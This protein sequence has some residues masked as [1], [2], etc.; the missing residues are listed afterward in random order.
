MKVKVYIDGSEGT[1]KRRTFVNEGNQ[2]RT[3]SNALDGHQ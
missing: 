1:T 3:L 2:P